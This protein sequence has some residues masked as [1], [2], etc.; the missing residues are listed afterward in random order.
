MIRF[1]L[2]DTVAIKLTPHGRAFLEAEH[3]M[4]NAKTGRSAPYAPPV[5]KEGVS[6]WQV[7]TLMNVFGGEMLPGNSD[8]PFY[9]DMYLASKTRKRVGWYT[10]E[11][12]VTQCDDADAAFKYGWSPVWVEA[13]VKQ[14]EKA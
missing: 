11:G 6:M 4:F 9:T 10:P 5:E 7:W 14:G 13:D 1:S 12:S 2:N 3:T 8:L